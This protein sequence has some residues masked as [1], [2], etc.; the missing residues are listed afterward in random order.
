MIVPELDFPEGKGPDT[1]WMLVQA[2]QNLLDDDPRSA[3]LFDRRHEADADGETRPIRINQSNIAIESGKLN[4][5]KL[6][7][8]ENPTY[9]KLA[10]FVAQ[11]RPTHGVSGN[12]TERLK[13][14]SEDIATLTQKVRVLRSRM[15]EAINARN[16]AEGELLDAQEQIVRLKKGRST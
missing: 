10:E 8:G 2:L 6:I 15:F 16:V 3:E 1:Y 9:P 13:R 12:T 14:Q 11:L 5:R 7:L 4:R